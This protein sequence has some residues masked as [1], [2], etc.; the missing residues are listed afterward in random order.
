MVRSFTSTWEFITRDIR[1]KATIVYDEIKLEIVAV[2]DT[3]ATNTCISMSVVEK[4]GAIPEAM[5]PM[6]TPNDSRLAGVYFADIILPN[7]VVFTDLQILDAKIKGID[8]LIGMDI[9]ARGV[10]AITHPDGKTVFTYQIP[11]QETIDFV[12]KTRINN[13]LKGKSAKSASQSGMVKRR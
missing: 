4:L 11:S 7:D 12:K 9:I 3:G 1:T 6:E 2:W 13:L 5:H 10:F 8:M